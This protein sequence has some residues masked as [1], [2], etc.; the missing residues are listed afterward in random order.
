[1]VVVKLFSQDYFGVH[2]LG[3]ANFFYRNAFKMM[4]WQLP[5]RFLEMLSKL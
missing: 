3:V 5:N 4:T 2:N 1:M